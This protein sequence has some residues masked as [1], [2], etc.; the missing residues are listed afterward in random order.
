LI[1]VAYVLIVLCSTLVGFFYSNNFKN[2]VSELNEVHRALVQLQNEIL[3]TYTPLPEAIKNVSEKSKHPINMLFKAVYED[4]YSNKVESVYGAFISA[5]N[6]NK[7]YLAL[8]KEDI[9][10]VL[11]MAKTLGESDLDGHRRIFDLAISELNK[12]IEIAE[13]LMKENVKM[14]RF[15]GFSAGA[16]IVIMLI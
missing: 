7:E 9:D 5:V 13:K 6:L 2:R 15:L 14:Y 16:L 12:K 4:L 8:K 11:D 10:V 3:Y 1:T